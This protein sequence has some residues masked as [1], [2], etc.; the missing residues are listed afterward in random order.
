MLGLSNRNMVPMKRCCGISFALGIAFLCAVTGCSSEAEDRGLSSQQQFDTTVWKQGDTKVRGEMAQ[1]LVSKKKIL[2][3]NKTKS[4]I[5]DMLG[6]PDSIMARSWEYTVDLG[7][8]YLGASWMYRVKVIF[9]EQ[10]KVTDAML[11]D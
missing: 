4:H 6:P 3:V 8:D 9:S 11:L 10:E 2:L 7:Q 1:D 5:K